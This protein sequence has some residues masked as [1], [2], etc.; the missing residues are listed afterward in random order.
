MTGSDEEIE[1]ETAARNL[2]SGSER[3]SSSAATSLE[4]RQKYI[5]YDTTEK[6]GNQLNPWLILLDSE[7]N[8]LRREQAESFIMDILGIAR[9]TSMDPIK[10]WETLDDLKQTLFSFE[11]SFGKKGLLRLES[12]FDENCAAKKLSKIRRKPAYVIVYYDEVTGNLYSELDK[13]SFI[14]E[15]NIIKA[16][17]HILPNSKRFIEEII[18]QNHIIDTKESEFWKEHNMEE[19]IYDQYNVN[20][21]IFSGELNT[22]N[23]GKILFNYEHTGIKGVIFQDEHSKAFIPNVLQKLIS[24]SEELKTNTILCVECINNNYEAKIESMYEKL[25][26]PHSALDEE[27]YT[28]E[29]YE[30][31]VLWLYGSSSSVTQEQNKVLMAKIQLIIFCMCAGIK[32]APIDISTDT[33]R[34]FQNTHDNAIEDDESIVSSI[35]P[36]KETRI[37][38]GDQGFGYFIKKAATNETD[39]QNINIIALI[40]AK[41]AMGVRKACG[42]MPIISLQ[43]LPPDEDLDPKF[44]AQQERLQWKIRIEPNQG[45]DSASI[46]MEVNESYKFELRQMPI[47]F[48]NAVCHE[49]SSDPGSDISPRQTL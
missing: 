46:I 33:N 29:L 1:E 40:G 3:N 20:D 16:N 2:S 38:V 43:V 44:D 21:F 15:I 28:N 14:K 5:L 8:D 9:N 22:N 49:I 47:T 34:Q 32:V 42:N 37:K 35:D 18:E 45:I 26:K 41:H 12:Y 17:K 13:S 27:K 11:G 23:F 48:K 7:N 31:V 36:G 4:I 39:S 24:D 19:A 30:D 6:I 25:S 10:D